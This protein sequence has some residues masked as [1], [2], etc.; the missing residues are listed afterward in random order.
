MRDVNQTSFRLIADPADFT[1]SLVDTAWC[2][3]TRALAL[4]RAQS[5]KLPPRDPSQPAA[6]ID[7]TMVVD[8]AGRYGRLTAD[9]QSVEAEVA[10]TWQAVADAG[11]KPLVPRR[12]R[13]LALSLGGARLALLSGD[14]G[15]VLL[16]LF[17][18]RERWSLDDPDNPPLPVDA[19]PAATDVVV[20]PDSAI[21]VAGRTALLVVE[22]G[23]PV[24]PIV[25]TPDQFAPATLGPNALRQVASVPRPAGQ[26]V[27]IS[28]DVGRVV[29]LLNQ[30]TGQSLAQ[31]IWLLDRATATP[32]TIAIPASIEG[33]NL[34]VFTD[35]ACLDQGRVALLAPA[36][37]GDA[38]FVQRDIAVATIGPAGFALAG[39]RYPRRSAGAPRFADT[40]DGTV[41]YIAADRPRPLVALPHPGYVPAG[42]AL[43]SGL[44]ASDPDTVWHR[45][46]VEADLPSGTGIAIWARAGGDPL[47]DPATPVDAAN[48]LITGLLRHLLAQPQDA[49]ALR[50]DA[51]HDI[52]GVTAQQLNPF[53]A[54]LNAAPLHR[55]PPLTASG[56]ASELPFHPG[57]PALTDDSGALY[58]V[59]LQRSLGAN[60][61]LAGRML[62][63]VFV[64][65]GDGRHTPRMFA[66]RAYAPRFSY[67]QQYLPKLFQQ[68]QS[69]DE[70]TD[71]S[72]S[73]L[74]PDFRERMLANLEGMLTAIEGRAAAAELLL[75]PMAAPVNAL[76][77]LAS[78]LGRSIDA[79]WPEARQRRSIATAGTLLQWRGTYRGVCLALDVATDGAVRR[80]EIVVVEN[81]RLRRTMATILGIEMDDD[82]PMTLDARASGNS[83]IGD[84]L[85]LSTATGRAFLALFAPELARRNEAAAVQRFFDQYAN[86]VTILLHGAA[87]Q[88]RP[89][90]ENVLAAEMPAHLHWDTYDSDHSFVLGL[91]PLLGIDSFLDP[92]PPASPV[93]L[94]QSRI[95]RDAVIHDPGTLLPAD[96]GRDIAPP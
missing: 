66:C 8:S 79:S 84:T 70:T 30:G 56:I 61:R 18:L 23:A 58:E 46:Y 93:T 24:A 36:Q 52:Q 34:P 5:W 96:P 12:G 85:V 3:D 92:P 44:M 7:A 75:D 76:P 19:D 14:A 88:Q 25:P 72:P 62:D 38:G 26:V 86:R 60:R 90:V 80:G 82:N 16:S 41:Y 48:L 71:Q 9:R 33:T 49:T 77:W 27:G 54:R 31:V 64:L 67:Q 87:R 89:V 35:I 78:F 37:A 13:F 11:E 73:A 29:L 57:L 65:N 74:P 50:G 83:V 68:T 20:A 42:A 6:P 10:G 22:G 28:A 81:F 39:E 40:S 2:A 63:L 55:Q 21:F 69:A 94:N 17:D 51:V 95:G 45:A 43:R 59:L 15:G 1:G 4:R 91:S 47:I 53:V 32:N